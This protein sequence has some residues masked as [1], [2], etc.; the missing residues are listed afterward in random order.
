M[1]LHANA[2]GIA[3]VFG[4]VANT[5]ELHGVRL[6]APA[7]IAAMTEVQSERTDLL[8]GFAVP[9][10]RGVALNATGIFGANPRAFGHTGWGG[11]FGYADPATGVG[12]A[13]VMNRM[14]PELVGDARAVALAQAISACT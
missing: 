14:G 9:W 10:A 4:A 12:A 3:R 13:Y 6:L 7:A 8:L 1:N 2:D 11:S 5:G